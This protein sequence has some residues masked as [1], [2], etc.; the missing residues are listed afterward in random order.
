MIMIRK[1]FYIQYIQFWFNT[2]IDDND[3]DDNNNYS[4]INDDND[5]KNIKGY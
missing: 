3:D 4:D 2:D 5:N 1:R